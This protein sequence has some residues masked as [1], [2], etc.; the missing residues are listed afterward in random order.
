MQV[1]RLLFDVLMIGIRSLGIALFIFLGFTGISE[2]ETG[3]GIIMLVIAASFI[4]QFFE[5]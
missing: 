4:L 5:R 1:L 2:G 3:K